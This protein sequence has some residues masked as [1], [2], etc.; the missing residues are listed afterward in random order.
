MVLKGFWLD[1]N[2]GGNLIGFEV[3]FRFGFC[4]DV[5]VGLNLI[6]FVGLFSFG[7]GVGCKSKV[8]FSVMVSG[9]V[10]FFFSDF[11]FA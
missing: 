11:F 5:N 10:F 3:F 7:L 8:E 2:V 9:C 1:C 4:F 6:G